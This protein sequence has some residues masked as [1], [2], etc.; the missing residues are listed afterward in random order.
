MPLQTQKITASLPTRN[1]GFSPSLH[2]LTKLAF[3]ICI[4][5]LM[6]TASAADFT[7]SSGSSYVGEL[8]NYTIAMSD[9]SNPAS[10]SIS[11]SQWSPNQAKPYLSTYKCFLNSGSYSNL[12]LTCNVGFG[13]SVIVC[14]LPV[15]LGTTAS[16]TVT[17][18]YNPS[19]T[20]PYP[21]TLYAGSEASV[22]VSL[23]VTSTSTSEI[24]ESGFDDT[25]GATSSVIWYF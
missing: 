10:L 12:Q 14:S 15:G 2:I 22:T 11:F 17:N 3:I 24:I 19:S 13:G 5:A 7:I 1:N 6:G 21:I 16:I 25:V 8:T 4:A 20:K 18:V 9:H 23:T